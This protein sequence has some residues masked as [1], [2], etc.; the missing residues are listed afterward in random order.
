MF[1]VTE[2]EFAEW[3][4]NR[5]TKRLFNTLRKEREA[6][7]EGLVY[8]RWDEPEQVKGRIKAIDLLLNIEYS[9]LYEDKPE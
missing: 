2:E 5:T 7:K 1:A 4:L 6:M 3:L 9:D 8:D